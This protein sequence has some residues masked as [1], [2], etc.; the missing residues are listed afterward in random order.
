MEP[1]KQTI[2]VA[3]DDPIIRQALS[4]RLDAMGYR[5]LLAADGNEAL[6]HITRQSLHRRFLIWKCQDSKAWSC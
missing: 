5:V 3:D 4:D 6:A 1:N 2:L